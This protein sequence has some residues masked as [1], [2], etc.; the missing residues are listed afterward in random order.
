MRYFLCLVPFSD[1]LA[2]RTFTKYHP[3]IGYSVPLG[4]LRLQLEGIY[5]GSKWWWKGLEN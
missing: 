3:F 4:H 2:R 1:A 5:Y